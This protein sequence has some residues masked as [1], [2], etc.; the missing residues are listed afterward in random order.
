MVLRNAGERR[1]S[2]QYL[3]IA[4]KNV[5]CICLTVSLGQGAAASADC[6][7][8]VPI[9]DRKSVQALNGSAGDCDCE[10]VMVLCPVGNRSI[11]LNA[12]FRIVSGLARPRP[13]S[14]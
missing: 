14:Q 9:L 5:R 3:A 7:G 11:R 10:V 4:S 8:A 1:Y 12:A 13:D 2:S 6:P